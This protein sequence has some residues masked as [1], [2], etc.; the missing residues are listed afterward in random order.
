MHP[1]GTQPSESVMLWW[2]FKV[3]IPEEQEHSD[4]NRG[5]I[6]VFINELSILT[7]VFSE[8]KVRCQTWF[9]LVWFGAELSSKA[10][11]GLFSDHRLW[12]RDSSVSLC[13]AP[14]DLFCPLHCGEADLDL[15]MGVNRKVLCVYQAGFQASREKHTQE[16]SQYS[17]LTHANN[18]FVLY[19]DSFYTSVFVLLLSLST[20]FPLSSQ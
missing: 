16:S 9:G 2:S 18:T 6:A 3:N 7:I 20:W 17:L 4:Y 10:Q 1:K 19:F 11:T 13:T 14:R 15:S 5:Q 12:A 8:N